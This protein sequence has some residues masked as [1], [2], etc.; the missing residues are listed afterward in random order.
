MTA[1]G[2]TV[3]SLQISSGGV[4]KHAMSHVT[5]RALGIEGD[6]QHDRKHHGGP[7]RAVSLWSLEVIEDLVREGHPVHPGAAGENVTVAGI[8]WHVI[9]PGMQLQ[10]RDVLLEITDFA[11]PCR[12]VA[13]VFA[14]HAFSRISH[15][16]HPGTSR[17]YARVLRDGVISVGD[18]V[19][20]LD[21]RSVE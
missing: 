3:H 1:I 8:D 7:D 4:P 19:T 17:V 12:T 13:H 18:E 11:T 14:D 20:V 5:V 6:A 16:K 2:G 10:I 9:E 21:A 15:K